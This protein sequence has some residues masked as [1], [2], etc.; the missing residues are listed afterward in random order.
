MADLFTTGDVESDEDDLMGS[1]AMG[2]PQKAPSSTEADE[3]SSEPIAKASA[4]SGRH[5]P[6]EGSRKGQSNAKHVRSGW[7]CRILQ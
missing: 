2:T 1:D 3:K 5:K 7:M 4:K 6:G